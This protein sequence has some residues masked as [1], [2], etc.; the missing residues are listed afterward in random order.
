MSDEA[1]KVDVSGL[2]HFTVE[3]DRRV[4]NTGDGGPTVRVFVVDGDTNMEA[5]RFDL[6]EKRPHYHYNPQG[7]RG[8]GE[9]YDIDRVLAGDNLVA[10]V[11]DTLDNSLADMLRHGGHDD[12][13]ESLN[14]EDDSYM[15]STARV[16]EILEDNAVPA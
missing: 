14:L 9:R 6:F 7:E 5:L 1:I 3:K 15:D 13:A 10:W 4:R 16:R 8:E 12:A 2:V 11:E